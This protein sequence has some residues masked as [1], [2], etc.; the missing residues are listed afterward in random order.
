[1]KQSTFI[2]L[3]ILVFL[4]VSSGAIT[5]RFKNYKKATHRKTTKE[6]K[7]GYVATTIPY[8]QA[9]CN[10]INWASWGS[11][12]GTSATG[13]INDADGS[14]VNVTMTSNFDFSSTPGIYNYS[15][16]STYPSPIPDAQ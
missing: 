5:H 6:K 9:N 12:T 4:L 7:P 16:F 2:C 8:S 14:L 15:T 13:T 1:F 3:I 11:F 10:D